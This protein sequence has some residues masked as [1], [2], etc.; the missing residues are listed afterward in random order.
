MG[1]ITKNLK[2]H[3]VDTTGLLTESNP[4]FTAFE[5]GV[6]GMSDEVS[7]RA[8]VVASGLAFLGL[9]SL[10]GK[11]RDMSRGLFHITDQTS[12]KA[13]SLHD[14]LYSSLFSMCIAPPIYLASGS[15]DL[16]E[17][18]VGTLCGA[19]FSAINGMPQGFAVD[20][21]RDLVG[22]KSCERRIYP[23]YLRNQSQKAKRT[24]AIGLAVAS[25]GLMGLIYNATPDQEVEVVPS[26]QID[27]N[28]EEGRE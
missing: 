8:R 6:A 25:I 15:R 5:V 21:Y 10:Y 2:Q 4:V 28:L 1:K 9:G 27:Y 18:V 20:V 17:I 24:L 16:K 14:A 23:E 19:G 13:Q 22:I 7:I 11:G 26:Q 3:F 12:E